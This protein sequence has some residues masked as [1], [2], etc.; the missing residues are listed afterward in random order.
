MLDDSLPAAS[1][2]FGKFTLSLSKY[3]G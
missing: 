1:V 3:S 2:P